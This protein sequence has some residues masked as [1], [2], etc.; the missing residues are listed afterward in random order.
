MKFLL[1]LCLAGLAMAFPVPGNTGKGKPVPREGLLKK[2]AEDRKYAPAPPK[3]SPNK[4]SA[5]ENRLHKREAHPQ[6][7]A[8]HPPAGPP[9]AQ[10]RKRLQRFLQLKNISF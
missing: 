1:L 3:Y 5:P 2:V 10:E 9:V 7:P 6:R 8:Y 4:R